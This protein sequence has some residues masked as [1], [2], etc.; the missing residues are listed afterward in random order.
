MIKYRRCSIFLRF[1]LTFKKKEEEDEE[2]VHFVR[3]INRS[4]TEWNM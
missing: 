1:I 3:I 4:I 2:K